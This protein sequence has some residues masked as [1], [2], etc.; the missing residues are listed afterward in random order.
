MVHSS[1]IPERQTLSLTST[2]CKALKSWTGC[3]LQCAPYVHAAGRSNDLEL[4]H[5]RK[6]SIYYPNDQKFFADLENCYRPTQLQLVNCS[7]GSRVKHF[8]DRERLQH[9]FPDGARSLL[10]RDVDASLPLSTD[11]RWWT[12]TGSIK[13]NST[14]NRQRSQ[15]IWVFT[16]PTDKDLSYPRSTPKFPDAV[17]RVGKRPHRSQTSSFLSV[18]GAENPLVII[19]SRFARDEEPRTLELP[20]SRG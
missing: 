12:T 11:R 15:A 3:I 1:D 19:V 13:P 7:P 4:L 18:L 16:P 2:T 9:C 8:D 5:Y 10:K 20:G 6:Y 14:L 17:E